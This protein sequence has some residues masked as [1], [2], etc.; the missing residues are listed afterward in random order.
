MMRVAGPL[1]ALAMLTLS[2]NV[3]V[4]A[5]PKLPHLCFLTFDPGPL[6][7]S[8]FT[9]FFDGLRDM[10]WE[11]GQTIAIDYLSAEGQGERFPVLATGCLQ[12]GADIIVAT[13][14]PAAKAARNA[15]STV[16]IV[17]YAL[18]DPV[19]T[20]L[21]SSLAQPGGN[22]TGTTTMTTGLAAKRLSLLKEAVPGLSRVLVLSYLVDPIA[23]PQVKE[24]Q[25]AADTLGIKLLIHE[26]RNA[27]DLGPAFAAG[28]RE[29]AEG[30]LTTLESV[31]VAERERLVEL[32]NQYRLPGL[33]HSRL[34]VEAGGLMAYDSFTTAFQ[35]HTAT[36]VDK[37]LK[38]AQ[39]GDLPVQ[40][41]TDL[42]LIINLK[43]AKALGLTMPPGLLARAD[44]VLE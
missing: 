31:F 36:Y 25:G 12:R 30:V 20:G 22:V 17:M 9:P 11:D 1:L 37:I 29:G 44:E 3:A 18:G 43:A 23:A 26:I 21:V 5:E 24:L 38:G 13:T 34:V 27:D 28:A 7:S 2:L 8:R 41:A 14:T 35:V 6:K 42:E 10:G 16:P 4:H 19:A 39:P 33:Y 15:S 32:A 40:Q